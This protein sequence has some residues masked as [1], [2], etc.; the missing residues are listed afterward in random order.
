MLVIWLEGSLTDPNR[1]NPGADIDLR[2]A[3]SDD[4]HERLWESDRGPL[5]Q[6]MGTHL[7]LLDWGFIRALT[8]AEGVISLSAA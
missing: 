5:T 4:A 6:G 8:K 1:A 2:V 7:I 3:V